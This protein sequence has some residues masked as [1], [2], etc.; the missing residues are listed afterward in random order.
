MELAKVCLAKVPMLHKYP[1]QDRGSAQQERWPN[2]FMHKVR[3]Q[4]YIWVLPE[5]CSNGRSCIRL[6]DEMSEL[7]VRQLHELLG[8]AA[9][10]ELAGSQHEDAVAVDDGV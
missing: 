6:T 2:C 9:L 10:H 1:H 5:V 4:T 7:S 3:S 8:V